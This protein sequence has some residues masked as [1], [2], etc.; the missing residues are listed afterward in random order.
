MTEFEDQVAEELYEVMCALEDFPSVWISWGK[1]VP[2]YEY[3][4]LVGVERRRLKTAWVSLWHLRDRLVEGDD[5][6]QWII[7]Q[8][9]RQNPKR[10][11]PT[12]R[13]SPRDT[14]GGV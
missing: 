3:D 12:R 6:E 8:H 14:E 11:R 9:E 5:I 13:R 2:G 1:A 7:D 10:G 4:V